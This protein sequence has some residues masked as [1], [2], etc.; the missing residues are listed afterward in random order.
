MA[1]SWSTNQLKGHRLAVHQGSCAVQ[2]YTPKNASVLCNFVL[3]FM[4]SNKN[5]F[6]GP[7]VAKKPQNCKKNFFFLGRNRNFLGRNVAHVV[8]WHEK[9]VKPQAQNA[10]ASGTSLVYLFIVL[11]IEFHRIIIRHNHNYR[12]LI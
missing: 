7:F 5:P 1:R 11:Y 12:Y 4:L 10:C 6:F 9:Q 8:F 2:N 3:A